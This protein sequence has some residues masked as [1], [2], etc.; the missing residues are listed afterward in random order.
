MKPALHDQNELAPTTRAFYRFAMDALEEAGVPFLVGGAYALARYTGIVRHTKD[1]DVFLRRA[2][3]ERALA[4]FA[5]RGCE[6]HL[7]FPHWLAKVYRGEDF[8]DLIFSSGNGLVEVDNAWFEHAVPETVLDHKVGLCPPEE[9]IWSKCFILERERYDGADVNHLLRACAARLDWA[10]LLHRFGPDW[11]ILFSH[12][13]LFG[14]VYPAERM[15]IPVEVMETLLGRLQQEQTQSPPRTPVCQGTLLSREQYLP[16]VQ[17]WGYQDAR[18][19]RSRM[20]PG[21]IARWTDAIGND[22]PSREQ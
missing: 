13:V 17:L 8:I 20:S 7:T 21:E 3:C 5:R 6:A 14:Y 15:R 22:D 10:R 11:R 12:L 18:T 1:F 9:I 4:A 2:D 19:L 16:D